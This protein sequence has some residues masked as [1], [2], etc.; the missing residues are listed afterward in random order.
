MFRLCSGESASLTERRAS[1]LIIIGSHFIFTQDRDH[2]LPKP[3]DKAFNSSSSYSPSLHWLF[4]HYNTCQQCLTHLKSNCN[5]GGGSFVD[6]LS[7]CSENPSKVG[8][9]CLNSTH[10][11]HLAQQYIDVEGSY[12]IIV[13]ENNEYKFKILDSTFPWLI[14]T[15][16][17]T[18]IDNIELNF[19]DNNEL[20]EFSW[21]LSSNQ[22]LSSIKKF[23]PF[24]RRSCYG[25]HINRWEIL[26]NT[27]DKNKLLK[28]FN[29]KTKFA[30]L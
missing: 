4:S 15:N 19:N 18:S 9:K 30:K 23:N 1:V 7:K 27:F 20:S 2:L 11:Y 3:T 12:G 14:N 5:G 17:F 24:Y 26:H 6:Y 22:H 8:C 21:T 29:N 25:H 16:L 28:L 13:E 10:Y